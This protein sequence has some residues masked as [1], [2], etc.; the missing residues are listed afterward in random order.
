MGRMRTIK[1]EI[2]RAP[3][4]AGLSH[5]ARATFLLLLPYLDDHGYAVDDPRLIKADLY[6]LEDY[7]AA[8]V[9]GWLGELARADGVLCRYEAGGR[10]YLHVPRFLDADVPGD[11]APWG[12]RPQKPGDWQHPVCDLP[13]GGLFPIPGGDPSR[14]GSGGVRDQ[15]DT[16][17]V[18]IPPSSRK[19][20][21]G[22]RKQEAGRPMSA[23]ERSDAFDRFWAIYPRRVSK[24]DARKA[25]DQA[26]PRASPA[27]ILAG[28]E[29]YR[30]DPN[31]VL[32][33]TKYPATWLNRDCWEDDPEPDRHD[34]GQAAGQQTQPAYEPYWTDPEGEG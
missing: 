18:A 23:R 7:T 20:V 21:A 31:R 10:R 24:R 3:E 13:H 30:D 17:R 11:P 14:N 22:S 27:A 6:P 4:L 5:A 28:A 29:R 15:S 33:F 9:D 19:Q 26:L 8:D 25:F 32:R 2:S 1:P 34:S 12:Q 16:S